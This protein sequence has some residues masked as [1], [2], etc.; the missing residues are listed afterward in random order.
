MLRIASGCMTAAGTA[1]FADPSATVIENLSPISSESSSG[2]RTKSY[3]QP[4]RPPVF[5]AFGLALVAAS[6]LSDDCCR[7]RHHVG[8]LRRRRQVRR[9][10]PWQ[11]VRRPGRRHSGRWSPSAGYSRSVHC[12]EV[13]GPNCVRHHAGALHCVRRD[14]RW[15]NPASPRRHPSRG[16]GAKH[17]RTSTSPD[18]AKHRRTSSIAVPT[19]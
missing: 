16:P 12:H 10:R 5:F 1:S 3:G 2:G 17:T 8:R 14:A 7:L 4:R 18:P 11:H 13:R 19:K 6:S 9:L 15:S